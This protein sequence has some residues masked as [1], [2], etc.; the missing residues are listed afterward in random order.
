MEGGALRA[1]RSSSTA[2]PSDE[3]KADL[4]GLGGLST[5]TAGRDPA[6]DRRSLDQG[7]DASSASPS[8]TPRSCCAPRPTGAASSRCWSWPS[9]GPARAVLDVPHV[10]ARRAVRGPARGRAT[11]TSPSSCSSSTRRTCCSPTRRRPSSRRSTRP[12]GSSGPRASASSSCT[13]TP[14]DVPADV[15][16]QLGNRVQHALRAFTPDDAEG[17]AGTVATYPTSA[18]TTSRRLLTGAGHRRGR[19]HGAVRAGRADAGGVDADAGAAAP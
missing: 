4:K 16:A 7:A 14:K 15:L 1:A 11:P 2:A 10:A 8:S 13:Q 19:R 9:A 12:C 3:G 6:R 5:A 18:T 17:A